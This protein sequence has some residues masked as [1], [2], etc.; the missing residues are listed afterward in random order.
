MWK[1]AGITIG[2]GMVLIAFEWLMARRKKEGITFTDKQRMLGM[3]RVTVIL[4]ALVGW[5]AWMSD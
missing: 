5:I 3:L 1:A 4:A 2:L